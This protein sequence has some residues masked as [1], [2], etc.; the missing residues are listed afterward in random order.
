MKTAPIYAPLDGYRGRDPRRQRKR[1]EYDRVAAKVA[2]YLDSEIAKL[3]LD[4]VQSFL[5]YEIALA[6]REDRDLV[7]RIASTIDGGSNGVM[8]WRGDFNRALR[9]LGRADVVKPVA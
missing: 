3:P 5:S 2:R 7:H 8:C 4:S 9:N 6:I 1:D